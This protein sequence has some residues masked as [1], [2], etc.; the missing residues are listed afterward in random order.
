MKEKRTN[1]C[2]T[3]ALLGIA[4]NS[5]QC[6]LLLQCLQENN[7]PAYA[8]AT[9]LGSYIKLM[10]GYS[11]LETKIYVYVSSAH[12]TKAQEIWDVI[13]GASDDRTGG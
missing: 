5:I 10:A 4:N 2:E 11:M 12:I 13:M 8:K 1:N 9:G 3:Q 7:I 6:E